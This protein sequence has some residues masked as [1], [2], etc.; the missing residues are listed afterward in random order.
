MLDGGALRSLLCHSFSYTLV[1]NVSLS[2]MEFHK[3]DLSFFF[4]FFCKFLSS[5][6]PQA[7]EVVLKDDTIVK[8]FKY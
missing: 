2:R 8:G 1:G 4:F 7:V 5:E 6:L 3:H